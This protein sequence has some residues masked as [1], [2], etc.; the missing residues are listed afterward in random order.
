MNNNNNNN[1]GKQ[2]EHR[3]IQRQV[4]KYKQLWLIGDAQVWRKKSCP[5]PA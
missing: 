2:T 1:N 5:D 4:A 3:H